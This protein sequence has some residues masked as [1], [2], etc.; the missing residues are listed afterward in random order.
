MAAMERAVLDEEV[1]VQ[2]KNEQETFLICKCR[3]LVIHYLF[4]WPPDFAMATS[5]VGVV[6]GV[7]L[8]VS[9]VNAVICDNHGT[10]ISVQPSDR[11][12]VPGDPG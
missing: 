3:A 11:P 8:V 4:A 1:A 9:V 7:G 12:D 6:N 10:G 5:D 2:S